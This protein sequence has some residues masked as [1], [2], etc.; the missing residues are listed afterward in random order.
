MKYKNSKFV[1][2]HFRLNL[3]NIICTIFIVIFLFFTLFALDRSYKFINYLFYFTPHFIM[4]TFS[5]HIKEIKLSFV[6]LLI[7]YWKN[8]KLRCF[9]SYY[10]SFHI[11]I[12]GNY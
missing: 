2:R 9:Y 11:S 7:F 5:L 1:F 6:I 4:E 3:N 8:S 12:L 10:L